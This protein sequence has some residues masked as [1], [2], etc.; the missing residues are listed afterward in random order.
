[1]AQEDVISRVMPH[2]LEAE[3]SVLGS[4]LI[5]PEAVETAAEIIREEDFYAR[6]NGILFQTMLEMQQ[7]GVAIDPVT[8][9]TRLREKISRRSCTRMK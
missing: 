9:Q 7:K 2:S 4:M 5:D 6:Q 1:M 3:R 8:L